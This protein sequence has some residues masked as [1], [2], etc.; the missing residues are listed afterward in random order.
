MGEQAVDQHPAVAL[1]MRAVGCRVTR[2]HAGKLPY[3][4]DENTSE[5]TSVAAQT[6]DS[7]K[8]EYTRGRGPMSTLTNL[9][10]VDILE[11]SFTDLADGTVTSSSATQF[12]V[13]NG[14]NDTRITFTGTDFGD[15][16]GDGVPHIVTATLLH[17]G[18]TTQVWDASF[19]DEANGK[20]LAVFRCT[21]II[22]YPRAG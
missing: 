3:V 19:T 20:L 2:F 14:D 12:V 1:E 7:D 11:T 6:A 18:R 21:Q 22:P 13:Q 17:S 9:A 4:F 15:F 8:Q 10:P 16:D 5:L